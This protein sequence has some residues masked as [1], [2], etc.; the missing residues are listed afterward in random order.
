MTVL[1][2]VAGFSGF[3]GTWALDIR[4]ELGALAL[5]LG[6]VGAGGAFLTQLIMGGEERSKAA[7][8]ELMAEAHQER[9]D[10]LNDLHRRL[11]QDQ[12]ARTEK[13]LA[14]LRALAKALDD[15]E[16]Q[17][18]I[19]NRSSMV[20]EIQAGANQLFKQCVVSL[21]QSLKLW[22]T[23]Q[24]MVT[25]SARKPIEKQRDA[26]V[27]DVYE[28]IRQLGELLVSLQK[29][30]VDTKDDTELSRIRNELNQNL[31][32]AKQVDAR[33][34]NFEDEIERELSK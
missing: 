8:T 21:E 6:V 30:G 3:L 16:E 34:R 28:S 29:L 12:D 33:M 32:V 25:A 24:Q 9:E 20:V 23:A 31:K 4:P 17:G 5:L 19:D 1:P 18:L 27:K 13:S 10:H 7:L 2:F 22:H 11:E 26:V 14:D 15:L